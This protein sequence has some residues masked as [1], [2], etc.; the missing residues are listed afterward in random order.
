M[1]DGDDFV[2][3]LNR[4]TSKEASAYED[5]IALYTKMTYA[6]MYGILGNKEDAE[7]VVQEAFLKLYMLDKEQVP[8]RG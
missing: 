3:H 4:L 5:F 7:D 8:S 6:Y 2:N 1:N